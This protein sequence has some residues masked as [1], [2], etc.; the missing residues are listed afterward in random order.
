MTFF[1]IAEKDSI[2][3]FKFTGIQTR[4]VSGPGDAKEA[5]KVALA[6]ED[7][8]VILIT[9][10]A[11]SFIRDEIDNFIYQHEIPLILVIPSRGEIRQGKDINEFLKRLI[12]ISI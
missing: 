5:L 9:E 3:G 6:T 12:G 4:Q 7:V 10:K 1:C 11:S 8:G 2:L